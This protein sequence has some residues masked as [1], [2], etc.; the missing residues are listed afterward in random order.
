MAYSDF[1]LKEIRTGTRP[2]TIYFTLPYS[3][4]KRLRL[5]SRIII[6]QTIDYST[7][8]LDTHR[9]KMLQI[10]D[11][12]QAFGR[13]PII[14]RALGYVR[15]YGYN[16]VNI[17]PSLNELD[18]L[19]GDNNN[20]IENS[21][22]QVVYAPNATRVA[23]RFS[24]RTGKREVQKS[25]ESSSGA[26]GQLFGTHSS[27]V[28]TEDEALY[29]TTEVLFMEKN[30]GLLIVGNGGFPAKI[31]KAPD[32][33][34]RTLRALTKIPVPHPR[35]RNRTWL[36]MITESNGSRLLKESHQQSKDRS[37]SRK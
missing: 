10:N 14:P 24:E 28:S 29:N 17:T 3:D 25:R 21:H 31:S 32:Y 4:Q 6:Q 36:R 33:A 34:D 35:R 2:K 12:V 5:I 20:F 8:E 1:S 7:Q 16:M 30:A 18:R 23:Q 26:F 22:I 37:T 9:W 27:S 15:G 19:Y 13:M 11:E